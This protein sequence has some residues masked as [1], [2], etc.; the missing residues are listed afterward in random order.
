MSGNCHVRFKVGKGFS[1]TNRLSLLKILY[2]NQNYINNNNFNKLFYLPTRNFFENEEIFYNNKGILKYTMEIH[3]NKKLKS[4]WKLI[5]ILFNHIKKKSLFFFNINFLINFSDIENKKNI[6]NLI[7]Y[8]F[9]ASNS[10]KIYSFF[11]IKNGLFF[12]SK[13]QLKKKLKY[14]S[15]KIQYWLNDFFIVRSVI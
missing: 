10:L 13:L 5:R 11:L 14:M 9:L 4:N 8:I 7:Y 12:A 1:I 3:K 2:I 15:T 6:L